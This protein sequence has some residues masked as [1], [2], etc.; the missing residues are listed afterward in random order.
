MSASFGLL[1]LTATMAA[2]E[3]NV[4]PYRLQA[5]CEKLS[6]MVRFGSIAAVVRPFNYRPDSRVVRL[7]MRRKRTLA[8][9]TRKFS[10]SDE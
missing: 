5:T 7:R 3:P 2:G 4:T 9:L 6:T 1:M 8:D 10:G